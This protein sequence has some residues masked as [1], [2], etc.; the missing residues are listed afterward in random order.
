MKAV[1]PKYE[2]WNDYLITSDRA[3]MQ[4][5]RVHHWLSTQS[6]WALKIP[7][8]TVQG[9]VENS[10]CV[11]VFTKDNVQIGFARLITDY[12]VFA[13]LADVYIE[14]EHRGKGLSK[15]M[16]AMMMAEDWVKKL[17]RMLLAT[18]DAH[19]LYEQYGFGLLH[20]P[21]RMMEYFNEEQYKKN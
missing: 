6:H 5:E 7:F 16:L 18:K 4:V 14:K 13:Y 9:M 3:K 1:Q 19:T 21:E 10:F 8:D 20:Y 12:V 17:R 2:T 15:K 11:G